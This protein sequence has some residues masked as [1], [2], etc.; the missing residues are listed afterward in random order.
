[1]VRQRIYGSKDVP[2]RLLHGLIA[3]IIAAIVIGE[4]VTEP[5]TPEKPG[6]E[7]LGWRWGNDNG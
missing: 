3:A 7:L 1:M 4:L 2:I 6:Y 5:E